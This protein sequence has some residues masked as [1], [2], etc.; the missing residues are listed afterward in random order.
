VLA[1]HQLLLLLPGTGV[2]VLVLVHLLPHHLLL[3]G[4]QQALHRQHDSR[5][6]RPPSLLL[7]LRPTCVQQP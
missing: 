2:V 5:C 1:Q 3:H 4:L 6:L 7:L